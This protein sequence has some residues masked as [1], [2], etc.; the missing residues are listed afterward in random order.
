MDETVEVAGEE[1]LDIPLR[2]GK[3]TLEE[4]NYANKI[5]VSSH[6]ALSYSDI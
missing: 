6:C 5:I 2:R 3:W 4:E 1:N